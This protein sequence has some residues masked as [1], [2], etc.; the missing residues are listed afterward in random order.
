MLPASQ[1]EVGCE[2]SPLTRLLAVLEGRR[3]TA[4]QIAD[5]ALGGS[6]P[7]PVLG[8]RRSPGYG[9]LAVAAGGWR[10]A[11]GGWPAGRW[12]VVANR[13]VRGAQRA[14]SVRQEAAAVLLPPDV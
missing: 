6:D 12:R 10:L 14:P 3:F 11:A 9:L 8:W 13:I 5:Y 7:G 2:K 1:G 4:A